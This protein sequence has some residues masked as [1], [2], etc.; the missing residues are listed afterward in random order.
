M[1]FESIHSIAA[2]GLLALI[3][4]YFTSHRG[5][6]SR[7]K[8][9]GATP[10]MVPFYLPFGFDQLWEALSARFLKLCSDN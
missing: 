8:L 10:R 5:S 4:V 3:V 7:S 6:L 1:I 2:F 9:K